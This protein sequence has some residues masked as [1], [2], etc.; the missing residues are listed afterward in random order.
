MAHREHMINE[1]VLKKYV[2]DQGYTM[3]EVA[4]NVRETRGKQQKIAFKYYSLIVDSPDKWR[5]I[6]FH[7]WK[8][9][10]ALRRKIRDKAVLCLNLLNQNDTFRA[11]FNWKLCVFGSKKRLMRM[12]KEDLIS[13]II[14]NSRDVSLGEDL[15]HQRG[16]AISHVTSEREILM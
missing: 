14:D 8:R 12:R 6:A 13:R 1:H 11:F 16:Q 15:I 4:R 5:T 2:H 3:D 9:Y 10:I 7:A